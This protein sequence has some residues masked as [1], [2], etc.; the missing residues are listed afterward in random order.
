MLMVGLPALNM[1]DSG[2]YPLLGQIK[3]KKIDTCCFGA[4]HT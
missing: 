1:Q 4:K 2:F 3:E